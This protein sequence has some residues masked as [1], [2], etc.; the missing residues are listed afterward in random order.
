MQ[1]LFLRGFTLFL[2]V[3]FVLP[4]PASIALEIGGK[5]PKLGASANIGGKKFTCVKNSGKLVWRSGVANTKRATSSSS[6][7]SNS[8]IKCPEKSANDLSSGISQAR[9][10]LLLGM[11]E[12]IAEQC[13][14]NLGWSFRVGQR[15]EEIFAVTQDYITSRVTVTIMKGAVTKIQV[16]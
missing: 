2:A 5:C 8:T 16:G 6:N 1:N 3:F 13:A 9:A 14:K 11:F 4:E 15:D 10:D 12:P 7:G